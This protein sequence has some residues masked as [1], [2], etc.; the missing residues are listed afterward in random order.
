MAAADWKKRLVKD[1]AKKIKEF[2]VI[3]IV[4]LHAMPAA[5]LA[6]M[7][8]KLRSSGVEIAGGR[9]NLFRL[10]IE[11]AKKDKP[12]I[13]KLEESLNGLPAFIFSKGNPFS[14]CKTL[15]KG[16]I[17]APAKPGDVA[18]KDIVVPAGPTPFAPGPVISELAACKI[19]T[20]IEGGKINIVA[21]ATVAKQGEE[22]SGQLSS[23]LLRLGITPM[24]IGLDLV[25]AYE[26]GL[27]FSKQ[28]L[29]IDD[30]QFQH[31]IEAAARHAVNLSVFAG[32][33]TDSTT[34]MIIQKAFRDAKGLATECNIM[35]DAVA[36]E[37]VMK[38]ERQMMALS[39]Q[40]DI[41]VEA[42]E[43]KK[44]ETTEKPAEEPKAEEAPAEEK[45][46]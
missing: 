15:D 45:K 46:E 3:G 13:E 21:P 23:I 29:T 39:S 9:K 16:K 37:L 35:A 2:P 5:Q 18:P 43:P 4:N 25:A 26:N 42:P 41:K 44:E 8:G 7:R 12:G 19:K 36:E 24:E 32:I 28:V 10:A 27:V 1:Y 11:Q 20:K 38:A 31:N 14:L 40:L 17:A 33:L 6:Q 34:E 30:V 22:I